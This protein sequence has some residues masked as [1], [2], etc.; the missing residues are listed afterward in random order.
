MIRSVLEILTFSHFRMVDDKRYGL[1]DI[2]G[3]YVAD[4]YR[5]RLENLTT[6]FLRL[7]KDGEPEIVPCKMAKFSQRDLKSWW[8]LGE[9]ISIFENGSSV[10][11]KYRRWEEHCNQHNLPKP[12]EI[13]FD[14]S[15]GIVSQIA[16]G[17]LVGFPVFTGQISVDRW[18]NDRAGNRRLRPGKHNDF[19]FYDRREKDCFKLADIDPSAWRDFLFIHCDDAKKPGNMSWPGFWKSLFWGR[20]EVPVFY[21]REANRLQIGLAFMPKL[22]GDFSTYDMI[23]HTNPKHLE[24]FPDFACLIF[25]TVG[26]KPDDCI[27]GRVFIEPAIVDGACAITTQNPTILSSPKPSY[28]PNYIRQTNL[29]TSAPSYAKLRPHKQYATYIK[30]PTHK[31]QE[32]RGWKRYPPRPDGEIAIQEPQGEQRANNAIQIRLHT[33]DKG[34]KFTGGLVF[35]NLRPVELGALYWAMTFGD[36][37]KCR[38]GLGMGKSFGFGQVGLTINQDATVIKPNRKLAVNPTLV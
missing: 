8:G 22:A 15:D 6:G 9:E 13:S 38:H 31:N 24:N 34:A 18:E 21:I 7:G 27:K 10:K 2:S 26:P 16:T 11:N 5:R 23:G 36:N 29:D 3:N 37:P 25:G 28:F 4:S 33:I 14:S 17:P 19:M 1:R 30:T 12:L 32:L 20:Q 35:H